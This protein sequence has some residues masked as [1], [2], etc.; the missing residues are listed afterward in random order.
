M[1]IPQ[2]DFSSRLPVEIICAAWLEKS[3]RCPIG[4]VGAEAAGSRIVDS[5]NPMVINLSSIR[6]DARPMQEL[7]RQESILIRI[8]GAE[9]TTVPSEMIWQ[10]GRISPTPQNIGVGQHRLFID[11]LRS[12]RAGDLGLRRVRRRAKPEQARSDNRGGSD[13]KDAIHDLDVTP[14]PV[15]SR[16]KIAR[17]GRARRRLAPVNG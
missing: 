11:L 1:G 16:S 7:I 9:V 2:I 8:F 15:R 6:L 17:T 10:R 3:L 13:N 14:G 12:R 5:K 4:I